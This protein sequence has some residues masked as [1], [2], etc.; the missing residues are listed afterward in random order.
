VV[1]VGVPRL[2]ALAEA[3]A[4]LGLNFRSVGYLLGAACSL[5]AH[6][7]KAASMRMFVGNLDAVLAM[8]GA[9]L[10]LDLP[11]PLLRR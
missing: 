9:D 1:G 10:L 11:E 5:N 6:R 3:A 7:L 2:S 8:G 4:C